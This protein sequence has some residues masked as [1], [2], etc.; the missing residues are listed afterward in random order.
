MSR[1]LKA[2]LPEGAL[3]LESLYERGLNRTALLRLMEGGVD[4]VEAVEELPRGEL[5]RLLGRAQAELLYATDEEEALPPQPAP[6]EPAPEAPVA[7]G[8]EIHLGGLCLSRS[9]PDRL[10]CLG[11][12]IPLTGK[13]FDLLWVL[14]EE[15]GKCVSYDD[16]LNRVWPDAVVEPQQISAHKSRILKKVRRECGKMKPPLIRT[17]R[18]RGLLLEI[19]Q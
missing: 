6:L 3:E 15:A 1:R 5:T 4:S 7:T 18:G 11:K 2:G 8:E 10:G 13:E 19:P 16:L 14:A 12:E 17:I 9:R